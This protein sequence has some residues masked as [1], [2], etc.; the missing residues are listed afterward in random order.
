M[1]NQQTEAHAIRLKAVLN[2]TFPLAV[3]L[4]LIGCSA[5]KPLNPSFP[6]T[7]DSARGAI[8]EMADDPKPI[9]RPVVVLGGIYDPGLAS[10]S[11]ADRTRRL[12]N[13]EQRDMV[14]S[15]SFFGLG[16]FDRCRDR[17]IQRVQERFPSEIDGE[18]VEDQWH[19]GKYLLPTF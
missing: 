11:L 3:L 5:D 4:G 6:L 12:F 7:L 17:V 10:S 14:M 2:M 18:T 9:Q 8:R 1:Y 16:K 19:R 15:I 13:A